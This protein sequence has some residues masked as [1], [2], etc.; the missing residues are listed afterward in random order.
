VVLQGE[1]QQPH[2]CEGVRVQFCGG[3]WWLAAIAADPVILAAARY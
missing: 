1:H 2:G 3:R